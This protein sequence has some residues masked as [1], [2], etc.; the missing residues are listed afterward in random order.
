MAVP[1]QRTLTDGHV[2]LAPRE[3]FAAL[4]EVDEATWAELRRFRKA[5]V[6]AFA[7]QKKGILCLET[8]MRF[9]QKSHTMM[10]IIPVPR[11]VEQAIFLNYFLILI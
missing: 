5:L 10:H 6:S 3:H 8:A 1:T 2:I 9:G 7:S 11:E 4:N